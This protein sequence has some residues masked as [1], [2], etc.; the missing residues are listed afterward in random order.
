MYIIQSLCTEEKLTWLCRH[1]L[2]LAKKYFS[3]AVLNDLKFKEKTEEK[4][5]SLLDW[6]MRGFGIDLNTWEFLTRKLKLK[7]ELTFWSTSNSKKFLENF[8]K[9]HSCNVWPFDNKNCLK[10]CT[11][12]SQRQITFEQIL[13][14]H[15]FM[16]Q[17]SHI[18]Q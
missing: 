2:L 1:F 5:S 7:L 13:F 11:K 9:F 10:F 4:I 3:C 6:G 8:M 14:C 17:S 16:F 15:I 12:S 18:T